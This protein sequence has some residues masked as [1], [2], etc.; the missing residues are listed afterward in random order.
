[1]RA[2]AEYLNQKGL[3]RKTFSA[4]QALIRPVHVPYKP[5][6]VLIVTAQSAVLNI[7]FLMNKSDRGL[8]D[9]K[10]KQQIT[11]VTDFFSSF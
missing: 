8:L 11:C 9:V 5:E 1:M 4:T 3:L 6:Q 10:T 2:R 7:S